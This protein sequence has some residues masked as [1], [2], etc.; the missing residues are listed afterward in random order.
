MHIT[1]CRHIYIY[2]YLYI[3]TYVYMFFLYK[4]IYVYMYNESL[5]DYP[6]HLGV[7]FIAILGTWEH[8]IGNSIEAPSATGVGEWFCRLYVRFAWDIQSQKGLRAG[9]VRVA[10]GVYGKHTGDTR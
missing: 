2:I 3:S 8:E 5:N 10:E 1:V 4:C 7:Y 6:H 9:C